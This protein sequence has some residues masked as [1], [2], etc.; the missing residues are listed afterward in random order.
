MSENKKN[1]KHKIECSQ[2]K[3]KKVS[4]FPKKKMLRKLLVLM[5][6]DI[7]FTNELHPSFPCEVVSLLQEFT[8]VFLEEMPYGLPPLRGIEHQI[9][10]IPSCP[11]LNRPAYRTNPEETKE[12]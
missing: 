12:I 9:D 11:I 3:S 10:L 1:E 7:Y 8:N 2:E 6:K 4:A 5:Y